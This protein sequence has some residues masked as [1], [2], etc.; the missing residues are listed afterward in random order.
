MIIGSVYPCN[1]YIGAIRPL[2]GQPAA[3]AALADEPVVGDDL[4]AAAERGL[5]EAA[6][7]Q[8]W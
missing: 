1:R 3:P 8:P 2:A 4:P 7:D 5:G 6:S